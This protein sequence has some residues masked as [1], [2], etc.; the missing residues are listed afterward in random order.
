MKLC[1]KTE[2][3]Y[4]QSWYSTK[5]VQKECRYILTLEPFGALHSL[6]KTVK[7][8]RH[9]LVLYQPILCNFS[10]V[11]NLSTGWEKDGIPLP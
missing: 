11:Y 7:I 9:S 3:P 5:A 1:R 2:S 6:I 10:A 8:N 4:T